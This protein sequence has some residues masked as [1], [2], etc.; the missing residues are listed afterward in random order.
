MRNDYSEP[1]P[2]VRNPEMDPR[3]N[4]QPGIVITPGSAAAHEYGKFEQFYGSR[5][6][7]GVEPGNPYRFRRFPAMVYKAG[8]FQGTGKLVCMVPAPNSGEYINIDHWRRD[9]AMAE[10]F[11]ESCQMIVYDE[12]ELQ[13]AY[14]AGY[15]DSLQDAV[16][17]A[18]GVEDRIAEVA[19]HR[20]YEDRNM[21]PAAKAEIA[22]EQAER[23]GAH[24]AEM[25]RKRGRPRK[26]PAA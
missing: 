6:A 22:A 23:G 17:H 24:V 10:R 13:R 5:L 11:N 7:P 2:R 14:E 18:N 16:D 12:K 9:N 1:D 20:N 3:Y 21:S 4:A 26:N 15:R 19:A 8:R 25:P